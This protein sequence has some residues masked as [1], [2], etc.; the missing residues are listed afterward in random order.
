MT[1]VEFLR[2]DD[3][4]HDQFLHYNRSLNVS[5]LSF[6]EFKKEHSN[7]QQLHHWLMSLHGLSLTHNQLQSVIKSY[8]NT[9]KKTFRDIPAIH[10]LLLTRYNMTLPESPMT[11]TRWHF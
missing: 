1:K 10:T 5:P 7:A 4:L 6:S 11:K 3:Y 9:T 8:L 2:F